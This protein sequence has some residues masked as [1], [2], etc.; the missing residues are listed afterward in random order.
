MIKKLV[1]ALFAAALLVAGMTACNTVE[2]AG[3]DIESAGEAIQ[4]STE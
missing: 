2:G 1:I 4:D 3:E